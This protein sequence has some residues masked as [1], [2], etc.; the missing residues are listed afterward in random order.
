SIAT[1]ARFAEAAD[2]QARWR[3][4]YSLARLR[5]KDAMPAL[6]TALQDRD[7]QVREAAA[8]G[9]NGTLVDSARVDRRALVARVR[10]LLDETDPHL[11]INGLR[12]AA[13]LRDTTLTGAVARLAS[14]PDVGVAV[15]AETTL[16]AIGGAAAA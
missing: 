9:I 11:R 1:L 14:D 12:A 3:A 6:V 4:V 15:Q 7:P 10:R 13:S 16:G 5:S 8:R 2:P